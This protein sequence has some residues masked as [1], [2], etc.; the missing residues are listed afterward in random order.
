MDDGYSDKFDKDAVQENTKGFGG[1]P[2]FEYQIPTIP[3]EMLEDLAMMYY[4]DMAL[5]DPDVDRA[6]RVV[7]DELKKIANEYPFGTYAQ[8]IMGIHEPSGQERAESLRK[9]GSRYVYQATAPRPPIKEHS[10]MIAKGWRK[11]LIERYK[12][13]KG[14]P[15]RSAK[16]K[17]R[18]KKNKIV[19]LV[20]LSKLGR[21]CGC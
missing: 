19:H 4:R 5:N 17:P 8:G 16:G 13:K 20:S 15:P 11:K 2:K 7:R 18:S 3:E 14:P 9:D 21:G 10:I 12:E 6:P 1:Q